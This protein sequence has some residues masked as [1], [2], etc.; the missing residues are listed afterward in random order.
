MDFSLGSHDEKSDCEGTTDD[1]TNDGERKMTIIISPSASTCVESR[2][3]LDE[4]MESPA[5]EVLNFSVTQCRVG[6]ASSQLSTR[7]I[8]R[9]VPV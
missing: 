9:L 4:S 3:S 1:N 8:R 2:A 5:N 7:A 6:Q